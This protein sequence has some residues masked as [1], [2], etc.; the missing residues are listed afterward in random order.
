MAALLS[1]SAVLAVGAAGSA[2]TLRPVSAGDPQDAS[3]PLDLR[4]AQLGQA[5]RSL[6]FS[7]RSGGSWAPKQLS[8]TPSFGGSSE[9]FLCLALSQASKPGELRLCVGGP[10]G[11]RR[12]GIVKVGAQGKIDAASSIPARVRSQGSRL[13]ATFIPSAA[14]LKPGPYRWRVLSQWSGSACAATVSGGAPCSD[15]LPDSGT[16]A[17]TLKP[18][19]VVGCTS[20]GPEVAFNAATGRK[21]V[22]LT[23]DDGPSDYTPQLLRILVNLHASATFFEIGRE[24]GGRH[25]IMRRILADGFEIGDHTENHVPDPGYGEIS[26]AKRKIREATGFTPCLLRPPDG[27]FNSGTVSAAHSLGMRTILWNV[28]PRDWSMPGS[29]AIYSTIINTTRPGSIVIMHDGGGNRSETVAALPAVIRTLRHRG[30]SFA[31]VTALL[32]DHFIYSS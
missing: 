17:F 20:T 13:T 25:A 10:N 1:V 8:R 15:S 23:F 3:G 31:T 7:I 21:V 2:A 12:I 19:K 14:G 30:Y 11:R 6:A 29:G 27:I 16:L 32:G 22:A 24:T 28:D 18:V 4:A 26:A 5:G 9:R